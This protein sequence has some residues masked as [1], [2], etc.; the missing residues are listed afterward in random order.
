[1]ERGGVGG[2]RRRPAG[3]QREAALPAPPLAVGALG[4]GGGTR[5]LA[6][7]RE[8]READPGGSR[9]IPAARGSEAAG[10]RDGGR[11]GAGAFAA[12]RRGGAGAAAAAGQV[13]APRAGRKGLRQQA[14]GAVPGAPEPAAVLGG[15]ALRPAGSRRCASA[16]PPGPGRASSDRTAVRFLPAIHPCGVRFTAPLLCG[17]RLSLFSFGSSKTRLAATLSV[18]SGWSEVLVGLL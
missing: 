18:G 13:R 11:R 3:T 6:A 16:L 8:G 9:R 1:M 7:G 14:A 12:G 15:A 4:S 2:A 10:A 5:P 17:Q